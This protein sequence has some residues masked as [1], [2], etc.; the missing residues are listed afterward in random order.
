MP[1]G[2]QEFCKSI[3][4]RYKRIS[5]QERRSSVSNVNAMDLLSEFPSATE[6]TSS[7]ATAWVDMTR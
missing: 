7:Y 3:V 4:T 1:L 5:S 6:R 2:F